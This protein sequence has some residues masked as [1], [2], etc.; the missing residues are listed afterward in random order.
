MEI[1]APACFAG[2]GAAIDDHGL[3]PAPFCCVV[4]RDAVSCFFM[5]CAA[6]ASVVTTCA[7]VLAASSLVDTPVDLLFSPDVCWAAT[8]WRTGHQYAFQAKATPRVDGAEAPTSEPGMQASCLWY[9]NLGGMGRTTK[10]RTVI[11]RRDISVHL[12]APSFPVFLRSLT[13]QTIVMDLAGDAKTS[14]LLRLVE[15]H[16]YSSMQMDSIVTMCARLM[17]GAPTPNSDEWCCLVCRR[18]GC[19]PPI[20]PDAARNGVR[21]TTLARPKRPPRDRQFLGRAPPAELSW[22]SHASSSLRSSQTALRS[23]ERACSV[24]GVDRVGPPG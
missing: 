16:R 2:L 4:F 6:A 13:G 24:G 23:N 1:P 15:N 10:A 21:T 3:K 9:G 18:G 7:H 12:S 19:P 14:D 22:V 8:L 17:G 11:C 20:A 5:D